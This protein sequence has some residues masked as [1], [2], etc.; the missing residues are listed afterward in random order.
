MCAD[1]IPDQIDCEYWRGDE[2]RQDQVVKAV[3]EKYR[4][5]RR[6]D[7]SPGEPIVEAT[8]RRRPIMRLSSDL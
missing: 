8:V 3:L 1:W 5:K 2:L 6:I 7:L 4:I